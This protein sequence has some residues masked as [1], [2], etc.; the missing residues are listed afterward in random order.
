MGGVIHASSFYLGWRWWWWEGDPSDRRVCV[1]IRQS[2]RK[3]KKKEKKNS[4]K[5]QLKVGKADMKKQQ[6]STL[7][8]LWN[9]NE[10][11]GCTTARGFT[12]PN[13]QKT[14]LREHNGSASAEE[15]TETLGPGRIDGTSLPRVQGFLVAPPGGGGATR[16]CT[17][18][19]SN[20]LVTIKH[21]HADTDTQSR[22]RIQRRV[23]TC[24]TMGAARPQS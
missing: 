17:R 11:P 21:R 6:V 12:P 5:A 8:T 19:S 14:V 7:S 1:C 24:F 13:L 18:L 3:K 20:H 2:L 16:G 23:F 15:R 22:H 4:V 9:V 10:R